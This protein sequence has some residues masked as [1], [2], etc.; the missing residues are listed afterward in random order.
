M[1]IISIQLVDSSVSL[2]RG[3][4]RIEADRRSHARR[5]FGDVTLRVQGCHS[6]VTPGRV[7]GL[8]FSVGHA[9]IQPFIPE[10]GAEVYL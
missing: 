7:T 4:W 10:I 8:G 5:F 2:S 6:I 3:R 9:L 1:N